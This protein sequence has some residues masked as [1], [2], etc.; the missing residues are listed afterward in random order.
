MQLRRGLNDEVVDEMLD[1]KG[2]RRL[3]AERGRAQADG[4]RAAEAQCVVE[5]VTPERFDFLLG[6]AYVADG[7]RRLT[8]IVAAGQNAKIFL[9]RCQATKKNLDERLAMLL[10]PDLIPAS[11]RSPRQ[12]GSITALA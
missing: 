2:F 1:G 9:D 6:S 8:R 7:C 3:Q 5:A 12:S 10:E 11:K 4:R